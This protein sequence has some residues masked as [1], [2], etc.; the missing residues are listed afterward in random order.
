MYVDCTFYN[1][2][3]CRAKIW[4]GL[5][6]MTS[7]GLAFPVVVNSIIALLNP[8]DVFTAWLN[9]IDIL[10][11]CSVSLKKYNRFEFQKLYMV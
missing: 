4:G 6:C 3:H 10:F 2:W 1:T 9:Y 7:L 8:L 5:I 11:S